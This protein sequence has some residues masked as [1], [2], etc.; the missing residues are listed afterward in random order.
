MPYLLICNKDIARIENKEGKIL[1]EISRTCPYCGKEC[2]M[3]FERRTLTRSCT[4]CKRDW[5]HPIKR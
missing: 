4:R 3:E 2:A 5:I 1:L